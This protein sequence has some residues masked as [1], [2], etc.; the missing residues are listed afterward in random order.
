[1]CRGHDSA[2]YIGRVLGPGSRGGSQRQDP[3]YISVVSIV[4]ALAVAGSAAR[5]QEKKPYPIFTLDHFVAAMK[6]VG[7]AFTAMNTSLAANDIDETKAYLAI[8][9]DRLA[10]TITFWRDRQK[11]DALR[12]LRDTLSK[13]D[14]LDETLSADTVDRAA[15]GAIAK[16]VSGGCQACHQAYREQ[17]PST[18]A[19]RVKL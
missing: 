14:A 8:S 3:P 5:A 9:R 10:T 4:V 2:S 12:M 18:K 17:D 7:Q 15:A 19:Y 1:M 13:M 11:D 16:Q 6:T